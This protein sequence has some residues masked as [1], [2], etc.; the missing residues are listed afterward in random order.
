MVIYLED[1]FG[2]LIIIGV[3]L[4]FFKMFFCF[5]F[6]SITRCGDIKLTI[7]VSV[8]PQNRYATDDK[9]SDLLLVP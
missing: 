5:N 7:D 4:N 2:M 9:Q 8:N 1:L 6:I 3:F